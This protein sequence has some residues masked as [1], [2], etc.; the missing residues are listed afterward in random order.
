MPWYDDLDP[1]TPTYKIASSTNSRIRVIAGPGTGK[2]FAMER[3]VARLL[4]SEISADEILP[5]TFTRVA[6]EDLHRK[7]AQM[8]VLG[9]ANLNAVT[10]HSIA[11]KILMK[12]NVLICT[13]RVPRLLN[14]FELEPMISDL[15]SRHRGKKKIKKWKLAYEAAWARLQNQ[16]PGYALSPEEAAFQLDL[17]YWLRFHKAMLIGEV[18][19]QLH[20]YLKNNPAAPERTEFSNILVDEYQDLNYAEQQVIKLLSDNAKVCV[21]GDADQSI[22]GFK[23]AHPDGI[24]G[25]LD[26]NVDGVDFSLP[27]CHRCPTRVVEIANHLISHNQSHDNTYSLTKKPE[28]GPG[29]IRIIQYQ[30]IEQEIEGVLNMVRQMIGDGVDPG[31]ILV[32]TQSRAFGTPLYDAFRHAGIRAK[33]YYAESELATFDAQYAMAMLK[34][35]ADHEDRTALRWLIGTNHNTWNSAGYRRVCNHC[36]ENSISPWDAIL[37]L[38][39]REVDIPYTSRIIDSFREITEKLQFLRELPDLESIVNDLLPDGQESTKELRDIALATI[40][41]MDND[42]RN[43]FVSKLSTAISQ[44][45]I[46]MDVD[47]VRIM[48]LHKSKGLSSPVT[49]IAGCV[50]G[51]LP[52]HAPND[53][54]IQGQAC[55][56]EEQRRLFYVGITRVKA[57]PVAGQPGNL[58]LTYSRN[59]PNQDARNARIIPAGNFFGQA[60]LHA[61]R[62]IQELGP[63]APEPEAG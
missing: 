53:L 49:I 4:E 29:D 56:L 63:N 25:W 61:S 13:N 34:I 2:S 31:N 33:S 43:A 60:V 16:L 6:A 52:T 3:R 55:F 38:V 32:L 21:V 45:E 11:L 51:L 19:P 7:L 28:N 9:C 47:D 39:N 22:Y 20:E 37:Q 54:T 12:N 24:S 36:E 8:N 58:I 46:P 44:P 23:H 17:I 26:E 10:L 5:V 48:S 41:E 40:D 35:F 50:D 14:K 27:V 59:M 62:F 30:N 1:E 15:K 57:D 42:N 18:I